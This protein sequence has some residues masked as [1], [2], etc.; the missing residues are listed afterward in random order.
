MPACPH[1]HVY[2][3]LWSPLSRNEEG[4]FICKINLAHKFTRDKDGNFHSA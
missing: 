1:C 4:L 2:Q 3:G